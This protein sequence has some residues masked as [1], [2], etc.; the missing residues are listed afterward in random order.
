MAGDMVGQFLLPPVYI[1][2][3]REL[4]YKFDPPQ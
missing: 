1:H 2:T 3:I 4:G